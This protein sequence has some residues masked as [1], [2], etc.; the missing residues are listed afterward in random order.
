MPQTGYIRTGDLRDEAVTAAK[1]A[2]TLDFTATGTTLKIDV[3]AE[4]T[5]AAGVTIDGT[6]L[7]DGGIICADG[8]TIEADTINEA[9]AAAGV[10][11]DG[12]LIKDG[13]GTFIDR[14]TTTDGVASGTARVLGGRVDVDT[15]NGTAHTNSTDEAVLTSYSIP[16]NTIKAGTIVKVK[17]CARVS[18]D[19]GATTLTGRLRLGATT[20]T[21]TVLIQSGAVD[22]ST[23]FL[24]MGEFTLVGRAAPGAAAAVV[25]MGWYCDPAAIGGTAL[26]A[27]LATTNFATNGALLL[28]LTA[29]WSAADANSIRSEIWEVE[30]VG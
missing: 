2:D 17:F 28:E 25:G 1:L 13:G 22:T 15:A 14:V 24:F 16:A 21:G 18:A 8:A 30:I 20:L 19:A 23:N 10:T 26:T 7:K 27:N 6:K 3:I 11:V 12:A 29:D 5:A 9:T 4:S